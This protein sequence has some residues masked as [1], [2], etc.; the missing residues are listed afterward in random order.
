MDSK[1][2]PLWLSFDNS[3]NLGE[4]ILHIFKNGD[5]KNFKYVP[6]KCDT[7]YILCIDILSMFY[8]TLIY[9]Q[10]TVTSLNVA[11]VIG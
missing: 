5:G 10:S 9:T 4:V 2:K 3:D 1:M 11:H 8:A 7:V 6:G